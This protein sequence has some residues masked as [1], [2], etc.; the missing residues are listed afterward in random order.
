MSV[1]RAL[2]DRGRHDDAARGAETPSASGRRP[3]SSPR[4]RRR[5]QAPRGRGPR[6]RRG[7]LAVA[8]AE[9]AGR[10]LGPR[11]S[12]GRRARRARAAGWRLADAAEATGGPGEAVRGLAAP[13]GRRHRAA[14]A[15]GARSPASGAAPLLSRRWPRAAPRPR[16]CS[17]R[18][19]WT[20]FPV[21]GRGRTWTASR[22]R[23]GGGAPRDALPDDFDPKATSAAARPPRPRPWRWPPRASLP[24]A[25]APARAAARDARA[26][27]PRRGCCAWRPRRSRAC[28]ASGPRAPQGRR[29]RRAARGTADAA[30]ERLAEMG[31]DRGRKGDRPAR[32]AR[33]RR[34]GFGD[35]ARPRRGRRGRGGGAPATDDPFPRHYARARG[36]RRAVRAAAAP[37][38]ARLVDHDVAAVGSGA[39]LRVCAAAWR[40]R[41]AAARRPLRGVQGGRVALARGPSRRRTTTRRG[42]GASFITAR[43][44]Y[45]RRRPPR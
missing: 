41:G 28:P 40:R 21:D 36:G 1:E 9:G 16:P 43:P 14:R 8:D 37:A 38:V 7:L 10:R 15:R 29:D 3:A 18:S 5:G 32:R 44:R 11:S 25:A 12:R 39:W 42:A 17:R 24:D 31:F 4:R 6:L 13:P 2:R 20:T 34:R 23:R 30:V 19:V 27:G 26:R 35:A 22:R 45:R 33:R